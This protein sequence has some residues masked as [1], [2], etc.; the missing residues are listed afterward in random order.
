[1]KL[2]KEQI[3]QIEDY[4][5]NKKI[6]YIDI[7]FEILD[8]IISDVEFIIESKNS[9]FEE[10]FDKIRIKWSQT[11]SYK[12]S[13]WLGITNGGSKLF[14]D[15]CLKIYKPLFYKSIIALT[16]FLLVLYS[17]FKYSEMEL[18]NFYSIYKLV[19]I[20][21]L[22]LFTTLLLYWRF[23]LKNTQFK[24]SYSYMF[25]KNIFSNIFL[26]LILIANIFDNDVFGFGFFEIF[27]LSSFYTIIFMGY[28]FYKNHNKTV[29]NYKKYYV[30]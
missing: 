20:L 4:L 16:M 8:H 25:N 6:K 3:Q 21:T 13:F 7:R 17:I 22:I 2:T 10:A 19:A 28:N 5:N 24:T 18:M 9:S 26:S 23:K 15:H 1:M 27:F 14:I 12:W 30:K 29:S 11:F